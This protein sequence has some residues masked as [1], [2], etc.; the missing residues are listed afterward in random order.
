[1]FQFW[2]IK[3]KTAHIYTLMSQ[4]PSI[5]TVRSSPDANSKLANRIELGKSGI[6]TFL[7][8]ELAFQN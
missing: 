8:A 7:S 5:K 1:M 3:Q 6:S 2:Y 4:V